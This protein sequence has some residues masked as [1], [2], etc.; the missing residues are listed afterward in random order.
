MIKRKAK[1]GDEGG[2]T[3]REKRDIFFFS[4]LCISLRSTEIGP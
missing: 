3:E 4:F 1:E 2:G